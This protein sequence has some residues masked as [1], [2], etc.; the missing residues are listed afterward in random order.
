MHDDGDNPY[1]PPKSESFNRDRH[2]DDPHPAWCDGNTLVAR[3]GAELPDRC[4]KCN[5]PAGGLRF[6]RN[7]YWH[8]PGW[9]IFIISP[10]IYI[11]VYLLVRRRAKITVGLCSYHR[12]KRARAIALGWLTA[13]AGIG[14]YISVVILAEKRTP[15][16]SPLAYIGMISSFVLLLAGLL[17]GMIGSQVLVP[18]R[19]DKHFVRLRRVSPDYLAELPDWNA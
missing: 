2:L 15:V 13:L 19:I 3:K 18:I 6:K 9:F 10:L 8:S 12:K 5:A 11:I 1:A 4:I 17:G 7:I 16:I 14:F